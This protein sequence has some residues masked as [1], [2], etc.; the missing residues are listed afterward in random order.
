MPYSGTPEE[1]KEKHRLYNL[2]NRERKKEWRLKNKDKIKE[3]DRLYYLKNKEKVAQQK[4]EYHQSPEGK[5]SL[6][7][8][9]WRQ[10][11][12]MCDDWD[13]LYQKYLDTHLCEL[14]S[15]PL[16]EDT[17]STSTTRCLDHC[18][19]SGLFRNVLCWGC[20]VRRG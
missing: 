1:Q 18:H 20:N 4:K 12:V 17:I 3:K 15:C 11:G 16:T 2:K 8:S 19:D 6:R 5:K 13:A 10:R 7:I 9:R 14:C